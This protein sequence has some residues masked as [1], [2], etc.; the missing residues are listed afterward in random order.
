MQTTAIAGDN[1]NPAIFWAERY[2]QELP[3][4]K[5]VPLAAHLIVAAS[6]LNPTRSAA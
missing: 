4:E 6:K 1:V 2:Y 3:I 5:L